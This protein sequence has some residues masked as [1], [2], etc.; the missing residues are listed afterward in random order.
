MLLMC[1][2]LLANPVFSNQLK[3][4]GIYMA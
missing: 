4:L 3:E 1:W 2:V